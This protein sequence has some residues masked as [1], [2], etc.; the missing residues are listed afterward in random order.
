[1]PLS[2]AARFRY[3]LA[4]GSTAVVI[5]AGFLV[6]GL[7]HG[8]TGPAPDPRSLNTPL[9][10]AESPD[11]STAPSAG[12]VPGTT[13]AP[14][15]SASRKA[16]PKVTVKKTSSR[17]TE[18]T[19]S[20]A[21]KTSAPATSGTV[22]EQVLAHINEAR[23]AE[24]LGALTLNTKLSKAA[25]LH[26]QLMID[27][28]GLS[29]QC[30][31]EAGLGDRFSAQGVSWSTAGE[32][33]GFGSSGSS[34]AAMV[35]AANGLTDAMLAEV[36]PNDGHRKNLLNKSFTRIGLSIVRDSKGVTWMTQDF[37]G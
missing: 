21:K 18:A 31:G 7:A 32:N 8:G 3:T 2:A 19:A 33:I 26:T 24:G 12:D 23:V 1:M 27:G 37:V 11:P 6:A 28:C 14:S 34:D 10:A 9:A 36:P 15:A 5:G 4:A 17:K 22:A 35:R 25:A 29:H 16:S 20:T 13:A 30:S